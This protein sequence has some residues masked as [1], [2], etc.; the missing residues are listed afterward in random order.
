MNVATVMSELG[1]AADL[2][3]G[4]RVSAYW[5]D[6][7]TPP[8]A[9]VTWS[10]ADFDATYGR[11]SDRHEFLVTVAVGKI[12]ARTSRD[13]LAKYLAGS[14]ADSVKQAIEQHATT[15]WDSVRVTRAEAVP[16]I[17]VAGN[18]YLAAQFTCDVMGSG[19]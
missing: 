3:A 12:S 14:G 18:E 2:I 9:I 4:L 11:G 8:A 16:V 5:A 19:A 6:K 17:D 7:I 10:S 15:A 1:N 13:D